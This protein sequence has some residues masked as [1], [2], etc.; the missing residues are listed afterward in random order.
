MARR[1]EDG[2]R[3]VVSKGE[4]QWLAWIEWNSHA[5]GLRFHP[6]QFCE[7]FEWPPETP[8]EA[9]AVADWHREIR[10]EIR[11]DEAR[12]PGSH[13]GRSWAP[14]PIQ[15]VPWRRWSAEE[16]QRRVKAF[17]EHESPSNPVSPQQAADTLRKFGFRVSDFETELDRP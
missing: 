9:A 13:S 3:W 6:D 11:R 1:T 2:K 15:P 5:L 12:K 16:T 7:L 8:H 17:H 10:E 14:L 4:P